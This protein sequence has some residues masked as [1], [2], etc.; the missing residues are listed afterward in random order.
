MQKWE[1]LYLHIVGEEYAINGDDFRVFKEGESIFTVTHDLG[2]QGWELMLK[3][4]ESMN[5][6]SG[7]WVFQRPIKGWVYEKDNFIEKLFTS[8]LR[9]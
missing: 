9:F 8:F 3:A 7:T 5:N 1:Y 4:P 6:A 2:K